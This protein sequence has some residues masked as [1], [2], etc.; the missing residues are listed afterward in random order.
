MP[1]IIIDDVTNAIIDGHHRFNVLVDVVSIDYLKDSKY[2][3]VNPNN[4][5]LSKLDIINMG[6]SDN[7]FLPKTTQHMIK[8][9]NKMFPIILL[10]KIICINNII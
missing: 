7:N 10:S 9:N 4:K 2:I 1:S 3:I 5:D 8:I 6:L